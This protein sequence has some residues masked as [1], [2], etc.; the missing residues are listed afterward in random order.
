MEACFTTIRSRIITLLSCWMLAALFVGEVSLMS[1]NP[2][3]VHLAVILTTSFFLW[4][5]FFARGTVH[6][7]V[8]GLEISMLLAPHLL[9]FGAPFIL[10]VPE[11]ARMK[12]AFLAVCTIEVALA[13]VALLLVLSR[14]PG[15][16]A[17]LL[18][19]WNATGIGNLLL[20]G[21]LFLL[22]GWNEGTTLL[23]LVFLPYSLLPTFIIPLLLW[24]HLALFF[25]PRALRKSELP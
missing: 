23:P 11:L 1:R 12:T 7:C 4:L 15:R 17:R 5:S 25:R 14:V 6:G 21:L 24:S 8:G 10:F 22:A 19:L 18:F 16:N 9:R 13:L 3:F 2:Q 20:L